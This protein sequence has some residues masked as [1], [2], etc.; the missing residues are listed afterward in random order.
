M[1]T[2]L[3]NQFG[4]LPFNLT[5]QDTSHLLAANQA[6][7]PVLNLS[8]HFSRIADD[9]DDNLGDNVLTDINSID[10]SASVFPK[11]KLLF[12]D[13][14]EDF[15]HTPK[16][17]QVPMLNF[18]DSALPEDFSSSQGKMEVDLKESIDT[19]EEAV[20]SRA[21]Q[22]LAMANSLYPQD[23]GSNAKTDLIMPDINVPSKENEAEDD[24]Q[25][26]ASK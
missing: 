22:A 24:K 19:Q 3:T 2:N 13:E 26:S 15:E 23:D 5:N 4:S 14:N 20:L 11:Q 1:H 17:K 6:K 12:M 10:T 16:N 21:R 18:E 25:P 9:G 8:H 7:P